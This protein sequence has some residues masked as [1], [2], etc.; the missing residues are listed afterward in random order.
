MQPFFEPLL[1]PALRELVSESAWRQDGGPALGDFLCRSSCPLRSFE[2]NDKG[3]EDICPVLEHGPSLV[4]FLAPK[5]R[6][7][8]LAI[9][10]MMSGEWVPHLG[11]L[12]C[13]IKHSDFDLFL[14]MVKRRWK[15]E[16]ALPK[17][18]RESLLEIFLVVP[19]AINPSAL[20]RLRSRAAKLV[21]KFGPSYRF[22]V[23]WVARGSGTMKTHQRA[24]RRAQR[25]QNRT[26]KHRF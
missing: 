10:K 15:L 23:D 11:H 4:A 24:Q 16:A 21:A 2:F 18:E 6:L 1:L 9:E 17:E 8:P 20:R 5:S 3:L 26:L 22:I 7:P 12:K 19:G 13:S 14:E 25:T